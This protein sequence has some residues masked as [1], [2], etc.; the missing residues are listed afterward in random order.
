M[1]IQQ[2]TWFLASDGITPATDM[3]VALVGLASAGQ[4]FWSPQLKCSFQVWWTA[5]GSPHGTLGY[6][7][8][9]DNS[10][11]DTGALSSADQA[12]TQPTGGAASTTV[13]L[14]DYLPAYIR[15]TYT[16]SSGGSGGVLGGN[17][18][19]K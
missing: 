6:D 18:T 17:F 12:P 19:T 13:D 7:E 10:H 1:N 5:T 15:L 16:P 9:S 14:P 2:V 11:W 4:G 8:S 3:Q